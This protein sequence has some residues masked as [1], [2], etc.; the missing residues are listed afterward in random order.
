[1]SQDIY[2]MADYATSSADIAEFTDIAEMAA[3][4]LLGAGMTVVLISFAISVLMV[5]AKWKLFK[6]AGQGGWKSI[7]PLLNTITLFKIAGVSPL[8]IL[9]YFVVIIP[10]IGGFACL[11]I[12]IYVYYRLAKA[13]GKDSGFTVGLVLLNPIFIMILAFGK[14]EYQLNK[15]EPENIDVINEL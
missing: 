1:M 9:A 4:F 10:V 5:I 11:G 3:G 7:I 6:K 2:N 14:S 15:Q 13:F 8:W 12:T